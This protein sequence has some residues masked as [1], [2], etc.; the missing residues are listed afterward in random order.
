MEPYDKNRFVGFSLSFQCLFFAVALIVCRIGLSVLA[1][2]PFMAVVTIPLH[3]LIVW[4]KWW[5]QFS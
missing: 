5:P 4:E 2:V 3:L 1:F